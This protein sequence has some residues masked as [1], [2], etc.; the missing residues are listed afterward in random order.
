MIKTPKTLLTGQM[1][2]LYLT[3]YNYI[4]KEQFYIKFH[5]YNMLIS[6]TF[7]TLNMKLVPT[8]F[9]QQHNAQPRWPTKP[10]Q[11]LSAEVE[12]NIKSSS[13]ELNRLKQQN[14]KLAI[15]I[16]EKRKEMWITLIVT[17]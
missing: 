5:L 2:N 12:K 17:A 7:L 4:P 13:N 15:R 1:S 9:P 3:I 8:D 16:A 6:T 10:A 11:N 14:R